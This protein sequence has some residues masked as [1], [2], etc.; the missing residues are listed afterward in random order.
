MKKILLV[1]CVL[2]SAVNLNAQP[3]DPVIWKFEAVK[4]SATEYEIKATATVE[5][6][7]HI[8]SQNTDKGGPIPTAFL[9]KKNPLVTVDNKFKETGNLEKTYD[10]N[11]KVNISYYAK[12]VVFTQT[13]KLKASVKTNISGTVQYMVCND[14]Q[15]LPPVTKS[16][17]IQLQ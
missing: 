16:F 17:N 5:D 8:Y 7:W 11:L 15:C 3:K 1:L 2:V 13:A 12:S 9:I 6:P 4:K 10:K 14:E